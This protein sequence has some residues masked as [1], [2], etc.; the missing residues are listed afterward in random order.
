MSELAVAVHT[1]D[2]AATRHAGC[3]SPIGG[4]VLPTDGT[5]LDEVLRVA[6]ASLY[7]AKRAGRDRVRI[8]AGHTGAG[9]PAAGL[10]TPRDRALRSAGVRKLAW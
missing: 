3:P 9:G 1:P 6:D 8:A 7:A 4:A 2:C 5:T 10:L